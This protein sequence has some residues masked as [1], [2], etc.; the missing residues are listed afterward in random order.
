MLDLLFIPVRYLTN[1]IHLRNAIMGFSSLLLLLGFL[2]L[3]NLVNNH[4]LS[5]LTLA[6]LYLL[7]GAIHILFRDI[8]HLQQAVTTEQINHQAFLYSKTTLPQLNREVLNLV[9]RFERSE[10]NVMDRFD[11]V[12]YSATELHK[13]ASALADNTEQQSL[14]TESSAAAI[15]EMSQGVENIAHIIAEAASMTEHMSSLTEEGASD[16][17]VTTQGAVKLDERANRC[18]EL[19]GDLNQ[20]T[21]SIHS[22]TDLIRTISEQ[23]N[24]LALNAAIEAARAGEHGRGFAV[25]AQEVRNLARKTHDSADDISQ[26]LKCVC[27]AIENISKAIDDMREVTTDSVE[28][29]VKIDQALQYIAQQSDEL[30]LKMYSVA[31]NTEQQSIAANEVSQRIEEINTSASNNSNYANQAASVAGYLQKL[32]LNQL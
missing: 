20:Q 32:T 14:A 22:A 23:T 15:L 6:A 16:T 21:E 25:V 4:L 1:A 24:L 29:S 13:S 19:M 10:Q 30:K 3:F 18:S 17:R 2:P 11:E 8:E 9:K 27:D 28:S 7:I 12:S 26:Q 5:I 31:T